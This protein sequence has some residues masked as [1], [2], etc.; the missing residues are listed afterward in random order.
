VGAL[1]AQRLRQLDQEH[2]RVGAL[3]PA[4]KALPARNESIDI[5]VGTGNPVMGGS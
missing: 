5:A 3:A 4:F 2:L 1:H